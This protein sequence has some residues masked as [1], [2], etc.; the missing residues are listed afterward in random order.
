MNVSEARRLPASQIGDI[1]AALEPTRLDLRGL[2]R[3][4][5]QLLVAAIY[6]AKPTTQ[7][8]VEDLQRAVLHHLAIA[9]GDYGLGEALWSQAAVQQTAEAR[10][11][12]E[13]HT[14]SGVV[15]E[16]HLI[17]CARHMAPH[18]WLDMFGYTSPFEER[19]GET[20]I[21]EEPELKL[22]ERHRWLI[23]SPAEFWNFNV[24]YSCALGAARTKRFDKFCGDDL[25]HRDGLLWLQKRP[26]LWVPVSE[27]QAPF[28]AQF[29]GKGPTPILGT[30][31]DAY[32]LSAGMQA[33]GIDW[34]RGRRLRNTWA[35]RRLRA[36]APMQAIVEGLDNKGSVLRRLLT[37]AETTDVQRHALAKRPDN[38]DVIRVYPGPGD[39]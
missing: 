33:Q 4:H 18:L 5:P 21:Y 23:G 11:R 25:A 36:G 3:A 16:N 13:L 7:K 9:V 30:T 27:D 32:A 39:K 28:L 37:Y 34:P 22:W 20:L 2:W 12:V 19:R 31:N 26:G 10:F 8:R 24:V 1:V 6:A 14:A 29:L 17:A 35:V 15:R 38:V